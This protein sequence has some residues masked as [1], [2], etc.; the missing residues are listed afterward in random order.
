MIP[1]PH[2]YHDATPT[3]PPM[4]IAPASASYLNDVTPA[5]TPNPTAPR[6]VRMVPRL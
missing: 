3:F 2:G 6:R 4:P 1:L 5:G